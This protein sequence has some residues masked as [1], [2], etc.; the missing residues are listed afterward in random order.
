MSLP[1]CILFY[2]AHD[3]DFR[4]FSPSK[5]LIRVIINVLFVF[6]LFAARGVVV[7]LPDDDHHGPT[8]RYMSLTDG[9]V[10]V[11]CYNRD[12]QLAEQQ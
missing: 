9:P 11:T 4:Q 3:T 1:S 2:T 6:E 10:D 12:C 5:A 8:N 7:Q